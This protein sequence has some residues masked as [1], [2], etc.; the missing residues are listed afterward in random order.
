VYAGQP[1]QI[2]NTIMGVEN[3]KKLESAGSVTNI[4]NSFV[5]AGGK[6]YLASDEVAIYNYVGTDYQAITET[7][8]KNLLGKKTVTAYTENVNSKSPRIRVIVA[9]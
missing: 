6:T 1:V 9:K 5:T 3:M 2:K 4:E 7:E 8:L